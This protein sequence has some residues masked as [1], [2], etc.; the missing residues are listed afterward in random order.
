[1]KILIIFFFLFFLCLSGNITAQSLYNLSWESGDIEYNSLLVFFN[2]SDQY[3]RISYF[4]EGN[5]NVL[6]SKCSFVFDKVADGVDRIRIVVDE[7]K[8]VL[9]NTASEF[10]ALSF[11][12]IKKPGDQEWNGPYA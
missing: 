7:A 11:T 4:D 5:Y 3:I 10:G 6:Q 2:E 1:M 8:F 12:W 9:N